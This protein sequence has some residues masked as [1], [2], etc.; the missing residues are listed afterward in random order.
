MYGGHF[1]NGCHFCCERNVR[2]PYSQN[3]FL[4]YPLNECQISCLYHKM[5]NPL[6]KGHL[7]ALLLG[8]SKRDD[9]FP[10]SAR[11]PFDGHIPITITPLF[12][13]FSTFC[14]FFIVMTSILKLKIYATRTLNERTLL[15]KERVE[16]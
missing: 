3:C 10:P 2:W 1:E 9:S 4:G 8:H 5:H 12:Y 15:V 13:H 7:S 11:P 6:K 14:R 16:S